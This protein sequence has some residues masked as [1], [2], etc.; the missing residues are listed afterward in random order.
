MPKASVL[1]SVYNESEEELKLAVESILN[2]T[3]KD[4]EFIIVLDNPDNKE[5]LQQL[6]DYAAED[7]RIKILRNEKNIGLALSLNRAFEQSSGKYLIRMDADDISIPERFQKQIDFME[8]TDYD[9][10]CASYNCIDDEGNKA[11]K[12]IH[13]YTER[14]IYNHLSIEN[15]IHHPTVVMRREAFEKAGKYRNFPCAQDYDL[16]LRMLAQGSSMYMMPEELLYYRVSGESISSKKLHQQLSTLEYI[17]H[18]YYVRQKTGED[19]YDYDKYLIYI[20]KLGV[21]VEDVQRALLK[22]KESFEGGKAYLSSKQYIKGF[23]ELSKS[24]L[25]SSFYRRYILQFY[26]RSFSRR[27]KERNHRS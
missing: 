10:I 3:Y 5:R 14:Q 16:W 24:M 13:Y 26:K 27:L 12:I 9:L 8:S 22:S 2:Q 6:E 15:V 20:K 21:G 11:D 19:I 18:I 23:W 25:E 4:F 17:R 1:M 7:S